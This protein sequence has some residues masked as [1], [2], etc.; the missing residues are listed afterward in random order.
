LFS[1]RSS[2]R[3]HPGAVQRRETNAVDVADSDPKKVERNSRFRSASIHGVIRSILE[4]ACLSLARFNG[5]RNFSAILGDGRVN[6]RIVRQISRQIP[7]CAESRSCVR[8]AANDLPSG[9]RIFSRDS[10]IRAPK[11]VV[12]HR[13]IKRGIPTARTV[14]R[15]IMPDLIAIRACDSSSP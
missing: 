13:V 1:R 7:I 15:F 8:H 14:M 10:G 11:D 6:T 9:Q 3:D 5:C 12:D 4:G 2:L